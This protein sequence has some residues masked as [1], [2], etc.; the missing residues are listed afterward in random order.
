MHRTGSREFRAPSRRFSN[1]PFTSRLAAR[2][3]PRSKLNAVSPHPVRETGLGMARAQRTGDDDRARNLASGM[4]AA[5]LTRVIGRSIFPISRSRSRTESGRTATTSNPAC[6]TARCRFGSTSTPYCFFS[7]PS[8]FGLRS[9]TMIG[10][11]Y[12]A[13][14][15]PATNAPVMRPPPRKTVA[16]KSAPRT[17]DQPLRSALRH[18]LPCALWR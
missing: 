14:R 2:E 3:K 10:L 15:N 1:K 12:F 18:P 8:F 16:L 9:C 17:P 4:P 13:S 11:S 5:R 7:C 6:C